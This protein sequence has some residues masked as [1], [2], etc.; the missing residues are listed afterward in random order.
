[1]LLQISDEPLDAQKAMLKNVITEWRGQNRQV[2]DILVLGF[3][4]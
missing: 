2:D 3:K 1:M 4:V